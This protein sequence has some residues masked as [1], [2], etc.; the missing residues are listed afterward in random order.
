MTRF[1]IDTRISRI[2]KKHNKIFYDRRMKF[3]DLFIF[4][5]H[6]WLNNVFS[7]II[8]QNDTNYFYV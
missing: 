4:S 6:G 3:N 2:C 1:I 5:M 8:Y 7:F